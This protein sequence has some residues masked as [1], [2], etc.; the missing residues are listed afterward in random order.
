MGVPHVPIVSYP[1]VP[2]SD[3]SEE[4]IRKVTEVVAPAVVDALIANRTAAGEI[5]QADGD[6][7]A[8][9]LGR[10]PQI[11]FRG[12]LDEIHDYFLDRYWTDG[13]PIV[14]PTPDRVRLSSGSTDRHPDELLG[15]AVAGTAGG[16]RVERGGQ[17]RDGGC[18]PEYMPLLLAAVE[19]I[20][21]PEFGSRRQ[22][23]RPVGSRS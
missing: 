5:N 17:R 7:G 18:A 11:V 2:L 20:A 13:L 22:G 3:T 1:G 4:F 9:Q 23:Q 15:R 10:L 14:P 6:T 21:D 12:S 16:H 19:C 8:R